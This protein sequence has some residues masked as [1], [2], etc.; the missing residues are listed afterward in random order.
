[1][2]DVIHQE[3][4]S[5]KYYYELAFVVKLTSNLCGRTPNNRFFIESNGF[6][7]HASNEFNIHT[8]QTISIY[9]ERIWNS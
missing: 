4:G 6:Q 3:R 8:Y 1:M 9:N 5:F 2:E 7:Y